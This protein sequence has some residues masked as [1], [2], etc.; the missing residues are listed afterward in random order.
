MVRVSLLTV[1]VALFLGACTRE[2]VRPADGGVLDTGQTDAVVTAD[3]ASDGSIAPADLRKLDLSDPDFPVSRDL[4]ATPDTWPP[5]LP[6]K[7]DLPPKPDLG[8][9]GCVTNAD[10]PGKAQF[11]NLPLGCTPPG[12]CQPRPS[13]CSFIYDPVCGCDNKDYGN[14]CLANSQ[15]V[16]VKH[17]GTC[18]GG[19]S[20]T[21]IRADYTAA[22]AAAK[23]CAPM[24]PVVQCTAVVEKDLACGCS[25]AVNQT[26]VIEYAKLVALQQQWK[27]QQCDQQPWACPAIPCP[28]VSTGKCDA[29]TSQCV[30]V[31]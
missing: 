13:N 23:K 31:P 5:D 12:T 1:G 16:S 4:P 29:T 8:P 27:A 30:D 26:N 6:P 11:C 3:G 10:C 25:T 21:Q 9:G 2:N 22:V 24:L 14:P 7:L 15:G 20:C 17:K 19:A 18:A 28:S